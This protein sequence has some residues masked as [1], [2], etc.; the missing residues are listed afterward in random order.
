MTC[1]KLISPSDWAA[2][3]ATSHGSARELLA[4]A[5]RRRGY[6][7]ADLD[8]LGLRQ[9]PSIPELAPASY[10]L[11]DREAV[12]LAAAYCGTIGWDFEHIHDPAKRTWI[13]RCAERPFKLTDRLSVLDFLSR[14][15]T[16][17]GFLA[18]RLPTTKRFGCDGAESFLLLMEVVIRESSALGVKDVTIGGMHRSRLAQLALVAGKPLPVLMS[19][20]KGGPAVPP[21]L[22]AASDVPYHLGYSGEREFSGRSLHVSVTPH[23]SHLE[24]VGSVALGRVRAKQA[25]GTPSLP[26]LVHTDASFAGQGIVAEMLQMA[27]LPSFNVGGTVHLVLNN[28][29][30]FTTAPE[31]GRSARFCTDIAHLTET[32]VLHVNGDD[33]EAVVR[34][35]VVA[36]HWRA[37]FGADIVVD[38]WAYRRNG[39][40]E[41][42][43]PRF[44]Q[45][46]MYK[47][48]DGRPSVA[49]LYAARL[50]TEKPSQEDL[51]QEL[52]AAFERPHRPNAVDAFAGAWQGLRFGSEDDLLSFVETG[53]PEDE[54]RKLGASLT[55][56]PAGFKLEPKAARF[57]E[58]RRTALE[59]GEGINWATAEALA[60]A[61]LVAE[62]KGVRLGG[63]DTPR[64][65]FTQRHL[66][67]AD[68]E[69]G[70]QH[71]V[72]GPEAE[73]F[74][75]PLIEYAVLG[76]E[77]GYAT[78]APD[79]LVLW[80]AQFGDFLNIA[81]PVFD[82]FLTCGEDRWQRSSGLVLLLPHG[83]D[84]GGP[85]H[86][87]ARPERLL[88]ACAKGN[89]QIANAS[90]P[91]NYFHLLR[92]QLH[93][94]FRKPLVVL[95]PK[96]LLRLRR[97]VSS[98][99]DFGP[100]TGF[101]PVI[102]DPEIAGAKRVLLCSGK[103]FYELLAQRERQGR[104][105]VA[106]IRLE[107]LYPL[108]APE[109]RSAL[110]AH[111]GAELLWCQEELFNMGPFLVLDRQLE[112]IAGRRLRYVGR[113]AA[114]SPAAGYAERHDGELGA[115]LQEAFAEA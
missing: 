1:H 64:G 7:A 86:S 93:R 82:Q 84:G 94:N 14:V 92:R 97:A 98:L 65:T 114:A 22:D 24:V 17:E 13:Q 45:P 58:Q 67:L 28:Q 19:E 87:T 41:I 56:I 37:A 20:V 52:Q 60:L 91:A 103:L 73:V 113:A 68:Q 4:L 23:P 61:S 75:S 40:N 111:H 66:I 43:E 36:A 106:I 81:Q 16:F 39:H 110:A 48:I 62:G 88:A 74:N 34:A 100:G 18:E 8:P 27:R 9:A 3:D 96:A 112:A 10:G 69:T 44:T 26:L 70:R 102:P 104:D 83:L 105:D 33:P 72:L 12:G 11:D 57:L 109:L 25:R 115:L 79:T 78:A 42:D 53:L 63:Q 107:Q 59:S 77:Y 80:E 50:G 95:A 5:F 38:L 29:V 21:G 32:P 46:L 85:D 71:R 31:D 15:E 35:G 6:L 89:I 47:A 51:R 76:F 2:D 108:P 99:R 90:T 101:R 55:A 49:T 30:G 54:L